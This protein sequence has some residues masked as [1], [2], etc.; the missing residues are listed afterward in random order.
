MSELLIKDLSSLERLILR[1]NCIEDDGARDLSKF[2]ETD[3]EFFNYLEISR[4]K[5]SNVGAQFILDALKK[6]TKL[7]TL[8][9]DYGNEIKNTKLIRD[10]ESEI[11][12]NGLIK[13][14]VK[15]SLIPGSS[16]FGRL[17]IN[18]KGPTYLRCAIKAIEKFHLIEL[19][20]SDNLLEY[21]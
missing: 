9:L 19:N 4:N 3:P 10:I 20:L 16:T 21:E 13:D 11:F 2:I 18:D 1:R 8:L 7:T 14:E 6:N 15:N 5:I 17:C 12:A